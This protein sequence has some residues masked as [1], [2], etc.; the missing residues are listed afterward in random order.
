MSV[1][2]EGID[3]NGN[4]VNKFTTDDKPINPSEL[5]QDAI[6][7][8][9][10]REKA[11][12]VKKGAEAVQTL[13]EILDDIT[14]NDFEDL[15]AVLMKEGYNAPR[16]PRYREAAQGIGDVIAYTDAEDTIGINVDFNEK[17]KEYIKYM[18]PRVIREKAGVEEMVHCSQPARILSKEKNYVEADA[19]RV[20]ANFLYRK[21][22]KASSSEEKADYMN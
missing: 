13:D 15:Y 11:H 3:E 4:P 22:K 21:M 7:Q 1:Y 9:Y 17:I 20:V 14:N 2:S 6:R 16:T 8:G 5:E 18:S 12:N 10:P 19:K